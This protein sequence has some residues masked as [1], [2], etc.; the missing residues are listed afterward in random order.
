MRE[1][2]LMTWRPME[3]S[4]MLQVKALAYDIH[5]DYP[6]DEAVFR[7]RLR[8]HPAGCYSL[9]CGETIAG[10]CIAHPWCLGSVP[11]LNSLLN[12]LPVWP[13]TLY[14]HDIALAEL[15][16]G[17][18]AAK[19]QI[20][21]LA[22]LAEQDRLPWISLT[23]VNGSEGFWRKNGFHASEEKQEIP[24]LASYGPKALYMTRSLS[25]APQ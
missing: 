23:A 18:F 2:K 25:T 4:D 21:T 9:V 8:L 3:L 12:A 7:E 15:A 6:E 24:G 16:R 10:Y 17:K 11:S 22:A 13:D 14:I 1:T 5:Q 19:T 20:A